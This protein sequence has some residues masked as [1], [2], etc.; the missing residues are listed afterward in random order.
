V[1]RISE[2][3]TL[4]RIG[5]LRAVSCF[6]GV[7]SMKCCGAGT[8]LLCFATEHGIFL[9]ADD[10]VYAEQE[11]HAIPLHRDF[12]KVGAINNTLIGTAGLLIHTDIGYDVN[13]WIRRTIQ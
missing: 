2:D 9:A 7:D 12:R 13:R 4:S 3:V 8:A 10:L 5:L 1:R 6:A 11:G